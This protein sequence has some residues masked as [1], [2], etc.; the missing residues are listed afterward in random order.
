MGTNAATKVKITTENVAGVLKPTFHVKNTGEMGL[1]DQL[2]GI[3]GGGQAI[4]R[5]REAY[6]KY[7][8]LLIEIA[9]LQT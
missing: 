8:K 2:I 4:Q 1:E 6:K 3:T 7:L 9:S 5:T